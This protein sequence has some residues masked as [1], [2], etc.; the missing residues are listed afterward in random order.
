M[1]IKFSIHAVVYMTKIC[2]TYYYKIVLTVLLLF[3][4]V[5]YTNFIYSYGI[6]PAAVWG[7]LIFVY[8]VITRKLKFIKIDYLVCVF[9]VGYII[10]M[11]VNYDDNFF[12]QGFVLVSCIM[13]FMTFFSSD[14]I[15]KE[16]LDRENKVTLSLICVFSFVSLMLSYVMLYIDLKNGTQSTYNLQG[17]Y[18]FQ[19]IGIYTTLST[20]AIIS[21]LS[22]ICS[23]YFIFCYFIKECSLSKRWVIFHIINFILA[24]LSLTLAYTSAGVVAFG[25]ALGVGVFIFLMLRN[26]QNKKWWKILVII[27][28]SLCIVIVNYTAMNWSATNIVSSISHSVSNEEEIKTDDAAAQIVSSNG[29]IPIWKAAM[30]QWKQEPVFGIGYGEFYVS[31]D[32]PNGGTLEY[33][34]VHSGYLELLVSCGLL[35]F[36]SLGIF[37]LYYIYN[38]LFMMKFNMVNYGL[39]MIVIY[40]CC[41]AAVNQ[42]FI[43][44]RAIT[45]LLIC[46]ILG[47]SRNKEFIRKRKKGTLHSM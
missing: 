46:I 3:S 19:L 43:L 38:F 21:G 45:V 25:A 16:R 18:L 26:K 36:V 14:N 30:Q 42:L 10:S 28:I 32:L 5:K 11:I 8:Q 15:S 29:R 20:Q 22:G 35:C 4:L 34:D 17:G 1:I 24:D 6:Y 9:I 12:K 31:F 13:Y 27:M 47:M 41:Y 40:S 39:I 44:D 7:S 33:R 37:G 2:S 23:L